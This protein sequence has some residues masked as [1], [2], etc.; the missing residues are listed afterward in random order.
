[1]ASAY[2]CKLCPDL[3]ILKPHFD[4]YKTVSRDIHR[5]FADYTDIIEPM[6]LN[7]VYLDVS[8][9]QKCHGNA[10]LIVR[11]IRVKVKETNQ[12]T[13]S[14]GV[15]PNKFLAKITSGWNKPNSLC[16]LTPDPIDHFVRPPPALYKLTL[17]REATTILTQG[18][19]S[20]ELL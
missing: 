6:S 3:I 12:I 8:D 4:R 14:A 19:L 9:C 5:A 10:T 18:C 7:E 16:I 15:A 2:A 1:M 13:V 17:Y 11:E 20:K